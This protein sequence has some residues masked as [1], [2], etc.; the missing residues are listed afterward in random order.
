MSRCLKI[1]LFGTILC[2]QL[3]KPRFGKNLILQPHSLKCLHTTNCNKALPSFSFVLVKLTS[4]LYRVILS[5]ILT[6]LISSSYR[7]GFFLGG[8]LLRKSWVNLNKNRGFI[9]LTSVVAVV[10]PSAFYVTHL[11]ETPVTGRRRFVVLSDDQ[12]QKIA[13]SHS[14]DLILAFSDLRLPVSHTL[15]DKVSRVANKILECNVSPETNALKWKINVINNDEVNAFVLANGHI[16]VFTGMLA[17]IQN[18]HEL[19]GILAHEMAHAILKHSSESV[20]HSGFFNFLSLIILGGLSAVIPTSGLALVASWFEYTIKDILLSLPYSRQLEREADEIGMHIAARACF[21]VRYLPKFWERMHKTDT[22]QTPDWLST[23][24]SS[25]NRLIWLNNILPIALNIR[26]Q[27][28]C[29]QL[30]KFF[31]AV[32]NK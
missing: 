7:V 31:E 11:E 27:Q 29:P 24:P 25:E 32:Q 8:R 21:D 10:I 16:F 17:A 18:E 4:S 9:F 13:D 5:P 1:R 20:S 6:K 14:E 22:K 2:N 3:S 12:M 15:H 30:N 26:E 19:A 23:H 28:K